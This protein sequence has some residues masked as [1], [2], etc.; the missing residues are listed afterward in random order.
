[1]HQ[2]IF[3]IQLIIFLLL[4]LTFFTVPG[5][6]FLEK[7]RSKLSFWE[8]IILGTVL[9]WAAFTLLGYISL[10]LN[11]K[12]LLIPI[13][14][15][16]ILLS[17]RILRSSKQK[18]TLLPKKILALFIPIFLTGIVMQL[19]IISSSGLEING[20][21]LFWSSNAHDGSWHIALMNQMEKYWPIQ[22]P[23][24]AGER[25]INYHF[26][27]DIAPMYLNY[28]FKLPLLD[29]YFRF[30]PLF[31]SIIFGSLAYLVGRKLT[32]SFWGGFWSF[33][34]A[35]F[36]GSFG[37]IIT[38]LKN[39]TIGGESLFWSSQPQSTI[40]NP[41]Q[42]SALILLLA[43][44]YLFSIYLEKRNRKIFFSLI[45][46]G[47][48]LIAFKVYAGI[49]LLGGLAICGFWQ[50]IKERRFELSLLFVLCAGISFILFFPNTS[51][52]PSLLVF[53]PW[54]YVRTL[55]V[56][57]DRL[58]WIDLELRR[59]TYI[60]DH[61]WKR[62]IQVEATA[63]LIFFFGNLGMRF[64]GL[65]M[66]PKYIKNFFGSFHHQL[67]LSIALISFLFPMLFLQKGDT[68]GTSQF[69]Q[70]YLL[71][72]GIFAAEAIF[73]LIK[74]IKL[75]FLK[76]ILGALIVL[77]AVPTQL[78]LLT[79]FYQRGPLAKIDSH[80]KSALS[81]LKNKTPQDSIILTPLFNK[82]LKIN[83]AI[84]S[85]WGWSDS[86]Y[87]GA[88]GERKIFLAD[89]EQVAN[90]GYNYQAREELEGQL[91]ETTDPLIFD[92]LVKKTGASYLYFPILQRPNVDLNKT[93]LRPVFFNKLVEIW[94]I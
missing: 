6:S 56:A 74:K 65:I 57:P 2:V 71:I 45:L 44:F 8:K 29:L 42:I 25:L 22:N 68:A 40:G 9:G 77:L 21:I 85:I 11:I 76:I 80:E 63:F 73:L 72:F 46:I 53:E 62:V 17:L 35:D 54:W 75:L 7:L 10:V 49:A 48:I 20:D 84:P 90:T 23:A 81:F 66:I 55:V 15:I 69:F 87:V 24:F 86:V 33:I 37:F 94:K 51:K 30:F 47:G 13:Y 50:L 4:S 1:M 61:N 93:S 88:F 60:A 19:L 70:Y 31:Y 5:I 59:Q 43:F 26:F 58:N 79:Q 27:S 67:L 18:I 39:R 38:F 92:N 36:A 16:I 14:I 83:E 3:I 34:F 91:F 28:F 89:I 41:P 78:G 64:V 82:Y 12:S 32:N 52:S